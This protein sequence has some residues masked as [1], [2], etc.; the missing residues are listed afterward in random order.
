MTLFDFMKQDEDEDLTLTKDEIKRYKYLR[1]LDVLE[2]QRDVREPEKIVPAWAEPL[3]EDFYKRK[4]G[5]SIFRTKPGQFF[6]GQRIFTQ[7][8]VQYMG[9]P[10][11]AMC[12]EFD[13]YDQAGVIRYIEHTRTWQNNFLKHQKEAVIN[14]F[15]YWQE[16]M[17]PFAVWD[18]FP[19]FKE[20]LAAYRTTYYYGQPERVNTINEILRGL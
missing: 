9:R 3:L 17:I 1:K 16:S 4:N 5:Y 19:S 11:L 15:I 8:N 7:D 12:V 18:R 2:A 14:E 6:L 20:L 13:V 10:I